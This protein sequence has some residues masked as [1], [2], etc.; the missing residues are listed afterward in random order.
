[1]VIDRQY[2]LNFSGGHLPDIE[3]RLMFGIFLELRDQIL[4]EPQPD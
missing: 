3:R 4:I 1:M 2:E